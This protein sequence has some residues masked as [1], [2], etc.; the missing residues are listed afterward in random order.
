MGGEIRGCLEKIRRGCSGR[1]G[2][3]RRIQSIPHAGCN[4]QY[5]SLSMHTLAANLRPFR[6]ALPPAP[7]QSHNSPAT[8]AKSQVHAS[9]RGTGA[10]RTQVDKAGISPLYLSTSSKTVGLTSGRR[11]A[12]PTAINL[13]VLSIANLLQSPPYAVLNE[14]PMPVPPETRMN[15]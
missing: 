11:L 9:R 13:L 8:T 12:R 2:A 1:V 6:L 7:T 10:S 5:H 15:E 4:D 14:H 3:F